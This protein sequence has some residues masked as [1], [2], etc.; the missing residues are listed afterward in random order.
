MGAMLAPPNADGREER[1]K[2]MQRLERQTPMEAQAR[3][4]RMEK[5]GLKE[6][7]R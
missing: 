1:E 7:P 2:Q 4:E 3:V 5:Q 6:R